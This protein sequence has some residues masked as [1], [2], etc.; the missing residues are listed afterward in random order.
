MNEYVMTINAEEE[1]N[2]DYL[3]VFDIEGIILTGER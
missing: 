1:I 3:T 2:I